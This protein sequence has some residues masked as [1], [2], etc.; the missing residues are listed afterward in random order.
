MG[1]KEENGWKTHKREVLVDN[2]FIKLYEDKVTN[3]AN[4]RGFYSI[5]HFKRGAVAIIPLD[6]EMNTW[7]VGQY[8]YPHDSYEWEVPE[9]G[10]DENDPLA[11]AHRE[12]REEVGLE[13]ERFD[14]FL[15]MQLS[16]SGTDEVSFSYIARGLKQVGT[17]PDD[18]ERL[19]V[20]KL[21]FS[22]LVEM[23]MRGEIRDALSIA[24]ILKLQRLIELKRLP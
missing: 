16:N 19:K 15:E 21:P 7:I 1:I 3:P 8:R 18:T 23:V 4:R 12:L 24:S 6:E 5:V 20:K 2:E 22:E 13:A 17:D 10:S 11:T 9:G 14:L